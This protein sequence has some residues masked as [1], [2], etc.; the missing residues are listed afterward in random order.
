MKEAGRSPNNNPV[1]DIKKPL[2]DKSVISDA[3]AENCAKCSRKFT[4]L[5]RRHLC[6]QCQRYFC[7]KCSNHK[8]MKYERSV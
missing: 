5:L 4:F 3:H 7:N 8:I 6:H 1:P 2:M